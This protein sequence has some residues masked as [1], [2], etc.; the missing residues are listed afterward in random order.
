MKKLFLGLLIAPLTYAEPVLEDGYTW[1]DYIKKL[2]GS[3][4]HIVCES[5]GES[6]RWTSD[7]KT[8]DSIKSTDYFLFND[9][10]LFTRLK[11]SNFNTVALKFRGFIN[12]NDRTKINVKITDDFIEHSNILTP[13]GLASFSDSKGRYEQFEIRWSIDRKLDLY[14]WELNSRYYDNQKNTLFYRSDKTSGTCSEIIK[15]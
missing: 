9:N 12:D 15:K 2:G 8:I 7:N 11:L 4:Q 14:K 5:S 10:Y 3:L 13:T 1:D 6:H